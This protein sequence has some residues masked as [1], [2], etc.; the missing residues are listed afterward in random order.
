MLRQVDPSGCK[1]VHAD[2]PEWVQAWGVQVNEAAG[3]ALESVKVAGSSAVNAVS[4]AAT[5]TAT[6]VKDASKDSTIAH[7]AVV[8][9]KTVCALSHAPQHLSL[10]LPN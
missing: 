5:S 3:E 10:I 8:V 4:N 9:G 7:G 1:L 6:T 2:A